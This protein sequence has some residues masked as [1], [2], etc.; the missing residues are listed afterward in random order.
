MVS[1]L[2]NVGWPKDKF[3]K[4]VKH[5]QEEWFYMAD[6]PSGDQEGVPDFSVAPLKR[7]NSWTNK[8]LDWENQEDVAVLQRRIRVVIAEGV[9]LVDM[10]H[11]MLHRQ[12]QP[13][14]A[15]ASS[16]W[17]YA[18][19]SEESNIQ[20]LCRGKDLDGMWKI[21]FKTLGKDN[22]FQIEGEDM[23]LFQAR[24]DTRVCL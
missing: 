2:K 24:P 16:L 6:V 8:N 1:K 14:Q 4:T 19:G 21:I 3:I 12:I 13:V 9:I 23:S 7:L 22:K 11:V 18:L 15:R 10:V 20:S 17:K 5:W